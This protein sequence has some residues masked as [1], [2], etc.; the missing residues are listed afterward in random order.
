MGRKVKYDFNPFELT[1][2][3]SKGVQDKG[4]LFDEIASFVVE[5]VK[6]KTS[7]SKTPVSN[8]AWKQALSKA[9]RKKTGKSKANLRLEGDLMASL[10]SFGLRGNT[11][12][13]TV[14]DNQQGKA[15]GHNNFTGKSGLPRR[16]FI[17]DTEKKQT[18]K[19]DIVDGIRRIIK[20]NKSGS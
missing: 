14:D 11:M 8:G 20:D 18:F 1:G 4:G 5:K 13:L 16:D 9:Y 12:R 15:D 17:P 7:A 3:S 6:S 10:E 19:K 2:Q